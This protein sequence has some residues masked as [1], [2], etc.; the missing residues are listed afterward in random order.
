[1]I[2]S[3]SGTVQDDGIIIKMGHLEHVIMRAT[4]VADQFFPILANHVP[5]V[6][7]AGD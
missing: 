4:N 3:L 2:E 1:M 5:A 7:L 6:L